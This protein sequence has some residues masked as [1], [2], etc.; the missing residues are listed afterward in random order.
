M[1]EGRGYAEGDS[2]NGHNAGGECLESEGRAGGDS[3]DM[4]PL[5][6]HGSKDLAMEEEENEST[7]SLMK[8]SKLPRHLRSAHPDESAVRDWMDEK[9]ANMKRVK[10]TK[11]RNLGNHIH[12]CKV[13]E[14]GHGEIL[15]RYRPTENVDPKD[16]VPCPSCYGYFSKKIYGNIHAPRKQEILLLQ[17]RQG[18]RGSEVAKCSYQDH[19]SHRK[20]KNC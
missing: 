18:G 3:Q 5:G 6:P 10:L 4:N 17:R 12:N 13:L 8:A 15:V 11:L 16:F 20:L 7:S 2:R 1:V 19:A 14:D 9:D